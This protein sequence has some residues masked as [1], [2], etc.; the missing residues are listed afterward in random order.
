MTGSDLPGPGFNFA[1]VLGSEAPSLDELLPVA[2]EFFAGAKKGW[3]ILVE[4]DAGHPMEAELRARGWAVDED[5]PA[6][7]LED[8]RAAG[9]VGAGLSIRRGTTSADHAAYQ[10]V[11]REAFGAPADLDDG[12]NPAPG[13]ALDP[14]IGLFI[15]SVD[16]R[17]VTAAGYSRSGNTAVLW[18]VATL[19]S[20]RGKG[21]GSA[22]SRRA[23]ADAAERGCT[24]AAL[25]SGPRSIPVYERIG[26]R[27]VCRHR[28][29]AAPPPP[30]GSVQAE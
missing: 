17:D 25:R 9:P 13:F 11:T 20:D 1:A 29:Y 19:E 21:Y 15:G 18:G 7:V 2:Q 27:F 8:I 14:D 24:N 12:F 28:T 26:F 23:L 30:E 16:G 22:V 4:G 10:Q 3:G 6:Y 5:E